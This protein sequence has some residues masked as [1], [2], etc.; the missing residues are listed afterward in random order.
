[1]RVIDYKDTM[2][3]NLDTVTKSLQVIV[4]AASILKDQV[5]IDL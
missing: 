3:L 1:M 4:Y 2:Q 5:L